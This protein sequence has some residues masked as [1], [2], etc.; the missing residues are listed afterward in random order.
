MVAPLLLALT[1][2]L[3]QTPPAWRFTTTDTIR[4]VD[5]TP[6]GAL[7]VQTSAG[8][9]VLDVETG[10]TKWARTDAR[11]F[12]VVSYSPFGVITT[13]SG[14]EVIDLETGA[15]KWAFRRLP[16]TRVRGYAPLP[17][18]ALM[19]V[20]GVVDTNP[21]V[22][23]AV[24]LDSGDVRW[25]QDGLFGTSRWLTD[26]RSKITL[27]Q[28]QP[29]LWDTDT[30]M[31]LYPS[32]GGPMKIDARTG[33]LLWRA[34]TLRD[35]DPP[36]LSEGYSPMLMDGGRIYVPHGKR[37]LALDAVT[38]RVLWDRQK[39][40]EGVVRQMQPTAHGLLVGG[41]PRP[42]DRGTWR[43]P[44]PFVDLVDPATGAS[45][46]EKPFNR[47]EDATRFGIIGDTALLAAKDKLFAVD[48]KSGAAREVINLQFQGNDAPYTLEALA[49]G[50]LVVG[51]HNLALIDSTG[52]QTYHVYHSAV[53]AS[54]LAKIASTALIVAVNVASAAIAQGQANR[55]GSTVFYP[56][57]TSNP[58]LSA[59]F[60][61][62]QLAESY[63]FL[64]TSDK[65]D[66]LDRHGFSFV[67]IDKRN[68][69]DAGRVWID[70]RTPNYV[71]DPVTPMLF[72]LLNEH[73]VQALKF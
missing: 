56:M 63:H 55:T 52:R 20:Y 35:D 7:A 68:G 3:Q 67:R 6:L 11:D 21:L 8:V 57:I 48:I 46:W 30:S 44:Q 13:D 50:F 40:F 10:S 37:L 33:A 39:Q 41:L 59:R 25:R 71:L 5:L 26:R 58:V 60:A 2:T 64:F 16:F 19:L 72:L 65:G 69:R 17:E 18:R 73:E 31:V 1:V 47:L 61:A 27:A 36:A 4:F 54:L 66:D 51:S 9:A 23:T 29:V 70:D 14:G 42:G 34:D 49:D 24:G 15:T 38:G 32:H 53:G 22:V 45:R 28:F 62:S 12:D 43:K